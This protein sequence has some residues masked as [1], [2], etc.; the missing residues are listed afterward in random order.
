MKFRIIALTLLI[1]LSFVGLGYSVPI[2]WGN[3]DTVP[4]LQKVVPRYL[5]YTGVSFGGT[6]TIVSQVSQLSAV[7]EAFSLVQLSGAS[8]TFSMVAGEKGQMVVLEKVESDS[9]T[10]KL[11]FSIDGPNVAHT[12]FTS[13]TWSTARGGWVELLWADDTTGWIVT[14]QSASGVTV[15]Y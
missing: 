15:T 13:V 14:G 7:H 4:V 10:L 8:K 3:T 12:G 2:N 1:I 9:N 5:Q 11:D 6:S